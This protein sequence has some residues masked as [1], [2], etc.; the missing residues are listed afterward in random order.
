MC[1]RTRTP[2]RL[3]GADKREVGSW[4]RVPAGYSLGLRSKT[5]RGGALGE[6]SSLLP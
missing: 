1:L 2:S 4:P 6:P 5:A 3:G